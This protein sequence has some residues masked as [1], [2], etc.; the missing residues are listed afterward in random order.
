MLVHGHP[1]RRRGIRNESPALRTI[2][3][4]DEGV[5]ARQLPPTGSPDLATVSYDEWAAG[6]D[7]RDYQP[8]VWVTISGGE[9]V[10]ITEQYQP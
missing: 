2:P 4:G 7:G 6:W 5:I 1:C 10:E 9:V 8:G 3:V